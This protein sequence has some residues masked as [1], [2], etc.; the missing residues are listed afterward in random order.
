MIRQK[1]SILERVNEHVIVNRPL[2]LNKDE[3][4][5]IKDKDTI[6]GFLE[7]APDV[8]VQLDDGSFQTKHLLCVELVNAL[9]EL[10]PNI[11]WDRTEAI[12]NVHT[13]NVPMDNKLHNHKGQADIVG[14]YF[15]SGSSGDLVIDGGFTRNII[16]I[17]DACG[18]M[19]FFH[20]EDYHG[21]CRLRASETEPRIT[22]AFNIRLK[23]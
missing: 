1:H 11:D 15:V 12:T 23:G 14:V 8:W 10:I 17:S 19:I 4:E 21:V 6:M 18:H 5:T 13:N 20:P 2:S 16:D 22:V 7:S 3:N 9:N